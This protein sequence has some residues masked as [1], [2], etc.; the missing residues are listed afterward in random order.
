MAG[1]N[2]VGL[3]DPNSL[4]SNFLQS[5]VSVNYLQNYINNTIFSSIN[6]YLLNQSIQSQ[7]LLFSGDGTTVLCSDGQFRSPTNLLSSISYSGSLSGIN[8]KLLI[9]CNDTTNSNFL[10][11]LNNLIVSLGGTIGTYTSSTGIYINFIVL[12][13][14]DIST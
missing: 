13:S 14:A 2:I 3:L 6:N 4:S 8:S 11:N 9:C 5:A 10:I 12:G 1:Y 7:K